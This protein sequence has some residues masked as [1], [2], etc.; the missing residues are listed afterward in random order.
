MATVTDVG[1]RLG[2]APT[3]AAPGVPRATYHRGGGPRTPRRA[4]DRLPARSDTERMAVLAVLHESRFEDI[5]PAE[6]YATLLDEGRYLCSSARCIACSRPSTKSG[7]GAIS[8][9]TL[10]TR[11]PSSW[12]AGPNELWS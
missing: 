7:N 11:L 3:C 2:I 6:V 8:C 10:A 1:L 4:G 12:P 5:A 9:G